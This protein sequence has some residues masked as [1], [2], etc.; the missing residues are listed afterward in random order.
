[1]HI[2]QMTYSS[3][4]A[5]IDA[6]KNGDGKAFEWI[7]RKYFNLL[8]FYAVK[9]V[10]C[11]VIAEDIVQDIF[12]KLWRERKTIYITDSLQAFLHICIRNRCRDYLDHNKVKNEY[13]QNIIDNND[14]FSMLDNDDPMSKLIAKETEKRIDDVINAFPEQ[15]REVFLMW[16]KTE[17]KYGEI[18]ER[19]RISAKA[20]GVQINRARNKLQKS[21]DDEKR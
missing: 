13:A 9:I 3:E 7:Y 19:L 1:M 21:L 8:R 18:A 20:V 17:L 12:E 16:L 4:S 6:L 15:C 11:M 5:A 14:T 2:G 10:R